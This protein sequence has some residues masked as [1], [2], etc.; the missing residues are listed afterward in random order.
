MSHIYSTSILRADRLI[1]IK[2]MIVKRGFEG[3]LVIVKYYGR[4]TLF[5]CFLL[6]LLDHRIIGGGRV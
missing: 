2:Y 5:I 1:F 3:D 6:V 4:A